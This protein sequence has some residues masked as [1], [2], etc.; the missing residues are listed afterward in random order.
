MIP[1]LKDRELIME[2]WDR[3]RRHIVEGGK[4][5]YPRDA[6]ENLLDTIEEQIEE[7]VNK[8]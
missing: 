8:K 3:W 2:Y 5:S 7:L 6:F 4:S 1:I